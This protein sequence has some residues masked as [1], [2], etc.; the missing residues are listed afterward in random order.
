MCY[1]FMEFFKWLIYLICFLMF[2]CIIL[3]PYVCNNIFFKIS[4]KEIT[5]ET[6]NDSDTHSICSEYSSKS[7]EKR[8]NIITKKFT[9]YNKIIPEGI[10]EFKRKFLNLIYGNKKSKER[11]MKDIN[12]YEKK[13]KIINKGK[14]NNKG[15]VK[16]KENEEFLFFD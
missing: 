14:N 1:E 11:F 7:E 2:L 5:T 15:S 10:F 6:I 16:F 4:S 3:T 13:F 9:K 12:G 8:L